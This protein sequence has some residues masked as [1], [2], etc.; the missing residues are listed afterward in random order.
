MKIGDNPWKSEKIK[1]KKKTINYNQKK[2]IKIDNNQWNSMKINDNRGQSL[3]I[4]DNQ[5]NAVTINENS[6]QSMKNPWKSL[7][8]SDNQ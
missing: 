8:I 5:R 3:K 4:N 2:F 7:T 6:W 1:L